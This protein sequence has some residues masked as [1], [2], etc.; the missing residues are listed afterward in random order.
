V[1]TLQALQIVPIGMVR[2]DV[3]IYSPNADQPRESRPTGES[4]MARRDTV[5]GTERQ[6]VIRSLSEAYY[7]SLSGEDFTR[8]RH[9]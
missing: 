4:V 9:Y 5:E 3:Y 6:E 1:A 2:M 7:L 8:R